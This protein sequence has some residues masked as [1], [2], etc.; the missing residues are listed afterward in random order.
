MLLAV[1]VALATAGML[2]GAGIA[3][4]ATAGHGP[5][6]SSVCAGTP[7][8]PGVLTGYH[9]SV[10]VT[11]TCVVNAGPAYV[12]R[13]VSVAPG[14]TL[15]AAFALNDRTGHGSSSLRVGGNVFV[16]SGGT[17]ILGCE[18][19]HFACIDDPNQK[20]PTLNS[21]DSVGA[22]IVASQALGV[23]VHNSWIGNSVLQ[24]GGGGGVTCTPSGPFAQFKSPVYSDYEDNWIG[25]NLSITGLQSC[26]LG[27]LRDKV[28]GSAQVSWNT[29]ADPDAMEINSNVVL[30][31]LWCTSNSPA[32]QFG[33]S[34]GTPNRVG[35]FAFGQCGFHVLKPNPAPTST[36]PAGPLE[37]ISVRL[38][39]SR[40]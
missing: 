9:R 6:G 32:V 30:G 35:R 33:D 18:A 10:L 37:H 40:R 23:V 26:W 1:L 3:S 31:N 27:S 25:G 28:R 20:N 11:G 16:G 19:A 36:T 2:G 21:S 7:K 17:L 8:S 39:R 24:S 38:F 5:H 14:G 12:R 29:M 34:M 4:A 22:S 13:D 15:L